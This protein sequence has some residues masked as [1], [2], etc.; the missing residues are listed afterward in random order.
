MPDE[1]LFIQ[2]E[3]ISRV[4]EYCLAKPSEVE[5]HS[6]VR[7]NIELALADMVKKGII[8]EINGVRLERWAEKL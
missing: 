3:L 2:E 6:F 1:K 4:R 8:T 5:G 7:K